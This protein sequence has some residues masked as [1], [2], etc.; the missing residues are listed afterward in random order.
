M[1][2]V[3]VKSKPSAV[4]TR[5][6]TPAPQ[7]APAAQVAVQAAVQPPLAPPPCAQPAAMAPA[8]TPAMAPEQWAQYQQFLQFQQFQAFQQ[9]MM[10]QQGQTLPQPNDLQAA[11]QLQWLQ[12]QQ[13]VQFQQMQQMALLQAQG[14]LPPNGLMPQG[15]MPPAMPEAMPQPA[16][17]KP[18][19]ASMV[20][21]GSMAPNVPM[22][23]AVPPQMPSNGSMPSVVPSQMPPSGSMPQTVP[24]QM[25]FN[26]MLAQPQAQMP[27]GSLTAPQYGM[28]QGTAPMPAVPATLTP[29]AGAGAALS[30]LSGASGAP[31]H[32]PPQA[33][34]ATGSEPQ[35]QLGASV[36]SE[37]AQAPTKAINAGVAAIT[38]IPDGLLAQGT[39][40]AL[41]AEPVPVLPGISA[42]DAAH[43]EALPAGT[44]AAAPQRTTV[45][46]QTT[47]PQR[48][49]APQQTTAP[50]VEEQEAVVASEG[51]VGVRSGRR[52]K[53]TLFEQDS[54]LYHYANLFLRHIRDERGYSPLTFQSYKETLERVIK[55]LSARPCAASATGLLSSWTQL[56]KLD[57]RALSRHLNF[58]SN[59][60]RYASASISH[61]VHVVSSFFTF[62]QRQHLIATNPM[63]FITAPKAKNALPR[64]LSAQE[65]DQLTSTELKTPQ[66]IRNRAI[67]ELLFSS[68]LRVGELISLNLGDISFDMREVRVVGKGDKERVVPVG[69]VALAA[70]EQ[71][72]AVRSYF[73]PRD[74]AL[75]VNRLGTRLNVRTVQTFIKEAA[76]N[77]G[78]TGTVTPHKLRH[79][80]ATE[81][82][83]HGADL[84]LVQ[85]M[86]GHSNLGTTQIY[87]HVDL[88]RLQAVYNHAHPRAAVT[89]QEEAGAQSDLEHSKALFEVLP[90]TTGP[91]ID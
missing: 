4:S 26:C 21:N 81:L 53:Q 14:Q 56:D 60:E 86:L 87:T 59:D 2:D 80:F 49:T 43:N 76:K 37:P 47:V 1:S 51:I 6:S 32:L 34:V 48:T 71:Y 35:K 62:L 19:P 33:A 85:E 63:Q 16:P 12:Y 27:Q 9:Q 23:Q 54:G 74:N 68:G 82:L 3:P 88:A 29:Q 15:A 58:K 84:R 78:L 5:Q 25:A 30:A 8:M 18:L 11:Q 41:K 72:L 91:K 52:I 77:T 70:I 24:P 38:C 10:L 20:P 66:D 7:P 89:A 67:T 40:A 17:V 55:F 64:V 57:M 90:Q 42:P 46:Q 28:P 45:P 83:N 61:A 13:F 44:S 22:A 31:V 69:R 73:K 79:S 65:I 75:F 50:R 39:H 36:P